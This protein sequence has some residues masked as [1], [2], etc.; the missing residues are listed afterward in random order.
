MRDDMQRTTGLLAG[1]IVESVVTGDEGKTEAIIRQYA[2]G[3][4]EF[5]YPC[6]G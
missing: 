1:L 2:E 6:S 5:T 4:S 3:W